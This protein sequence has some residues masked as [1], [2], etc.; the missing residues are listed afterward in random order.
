MKFEQSLVTIACIHTLL[1]LALVSGNR[2][3]TLRARPS[4]EQQYFWLCFLFFEICISY[5]FNIFIDL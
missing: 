2:A 5:F 4:T 3:A 1:D